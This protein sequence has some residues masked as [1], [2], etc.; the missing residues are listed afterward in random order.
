MCERYVFIC[1][2]F[3]F[4]SL[5]EFSFFGHKDKDKSSTLENLDSDSLSVQHNISVSFLK[6]IR[7]VFV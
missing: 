4:Y 5:P 6:P 7:K 3:Y 1:N 2:I